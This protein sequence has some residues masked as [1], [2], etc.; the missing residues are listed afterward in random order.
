MRSRLWIAGAVAGLAIAMPAWS[1]AAEH[2]AAGVAPSPSAMHGTVLCRGVQNVPLTADQ[3]QALPMRL[4]G[5]LKCGEE[6]S[7]VSD[8]QGYT[9]LVRAADG[10]NGYVARMYLSE[11][12][13]QPAPA[14]TV[15]E[16]RMVEAAVSENGIVRWQLGAPGT[17]HFE[18]GHVTVESLTANGITVQVSLQDTGWKLR[19]NVAIANEGTEMVHY[20]PSSFTLDELKPRLRALR[21]QVPEELGK[22]MTHQV[23]STKASAI[24]PASAVYTNVSYETKR[25]IIAA[26]NFLAMNSQQDQSPVLYEGSVA[27]NEKTAGA[28]WFERDKNP[29]DLNLRIF[30]GNQ[31]FEFPLSFPQHN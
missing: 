16:R 15:A 17:D 22:S 7:V 13:A 3:E 23:Y 26:P 9:V 19:A 8:T 14:K 27:P 12:A 6:V 30:V 18:Y 24:A 2:S 29:Q 1:A 28:V 31:I 5:H 10:T 21:Y 11:S 4:V 25:V 20:K